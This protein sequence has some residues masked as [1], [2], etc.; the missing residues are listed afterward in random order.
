MAEDIPRPQAPKGPGKEG[1]IRLRCL[2]APLSTCWVTLLGSL[3]GTDAHAQQ[4]GALR[5]VVVDSSGAPL[6]DADVGIRVRHL[7]TRTDDDGRFLLRRIPAGELEISVR[8]LGYEPQVLNVTITGQ[9]TDSLLVV[10]A[11]R[12][13]LLGRV[14]VSEREQRVWLDLEGFYRRRIRGI[15]QYVTRDEFRNSGTVTDMVRNVPGLQIVQRR[16]SRRGVRFQSTSLSGGDC[17]PMIWLD[18]QKAPRMELDDIPISDVEGI[19]LYSGPSTTPQQF[20]PD[21]TRNTCG[22]IVVWS[23]PPAPRPARGKPS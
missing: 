12:A 11:K 21:N 20:Y 16:G 3:A 8:R 10:L 5:G 1:G 14:E 9:G 19:E 13:Q 22:T 18:G 7:L 4:Q 23:R 15:G 17:M 2:V 6:K